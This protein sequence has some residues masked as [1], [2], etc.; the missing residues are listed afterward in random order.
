MAFE[1]CESLKTIDLSYFKT[2][3]AINCLDSFKKCKYLETVNLSHMTNESFGSLSGM[4]ENCE[5]LK[6]LDISGLDM[7]KSFSSQVFNQ[8]KGLKYINIKGTKL[9]SQFINEINGLGNDLTI[10][11]D[12]PILVKKGYKYSCYIYENGEKIDK[13]SNSIIVYFTEGD[14]KEFLF[15]QDYIDAIDYVISGDSSFTENSLMSPIIV[16]SEM[17]IFFK[18]PYPTSLDNFFEGKENIISVDLSNCDFSSINSFKSL[19]QGC[20]ALQS[21]NFSNINT[22]LISTMESMFQNCESLVS[23][24]LSNLKTDSNVVINSLFNGCTSLK[25]IDISGLDLSLV[26]EASDVLAGSQSLKYINIMGIQISEDAKTFLNSDLREK[27][28]LKVCQR[29]TILEGDNIINVCCNF[30]VESEKCESI[31]YITNYII[32]YYGKDMITEMI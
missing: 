22:S 14:N 30:N 27:E 9:K 4:F 26:Q 23:I 16:D 6:I 28:D 32:V 24:D 31:Y 15:N 29:E 7:E 12:R 20:S 10:C 11:Q 17:N 8:L 5:K 19:F 1:S 21:V 3:K 25:M 18:S 13:A 2:S